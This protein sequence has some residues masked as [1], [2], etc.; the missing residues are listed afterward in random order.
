VSE[1]YAVTEA[2]GKPAGGAGRTDS[3]VAQL[4]KLSKAAKQGNHWAR[5]V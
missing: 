5:R 3:D 4:Q 1:F 2:L